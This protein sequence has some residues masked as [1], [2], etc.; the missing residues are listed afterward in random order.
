MGKSLGNV[1]FGCTERTISNSG[2]SGGGGGLSQ[3]ATLYDSKS[4]GVN[5]G[6]FTSGAWITRDL[7]TTQSDP[8]SVVV[9]A[10]N[11]I[12]LAAG[13]YVFFASCPA[14][15]VGNH[16]AR[17]QNITAGTTIA[18]GSVETTSGMS[19]QTRSIIRCS[20]TVAV[21]TVVEVQHRCTITKT[22]DGFGVAGGISSEIYTVV[23]VW[24]A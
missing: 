2:P 24:P 4:S 22:V 6:T 16:Q 8:N 10:S 12:S 13:S 19:V 17:L 14:Y 7:N 5:G 15:S 21:P 18:E 1:G 3:P 20:V 11:Q 9:L 23:Q